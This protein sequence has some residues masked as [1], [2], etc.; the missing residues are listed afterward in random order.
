MLICWL[1]RTAWLLL[2]WLVAT[3]SATDQQ[4]GLSRL[5]P[6][7]R[8]TNA[9]STQVTLSNIS[10]IVNYPYHHQ[11]N[12]DP[13]TALIDYCSSYY[14]ISDQFCSGHGQCQPYVGC[15][16]EPNWT[17]QGDFMDLTGR[18]CQN[19]EPAILGLHIGWLIASAISLGIASYK[20]YQCSWGTYIFIIRQA[21]ELQNRKAPK[22]S[23]WQRL[24]TAAR[25][26]EE[27]LSQE[28][29]QKGVQRQVSLQPQAISRQQS[30]LA[31]E[32]ELL[33]SLRQDESYTQQSVTIDRSETRP[34][35]DRRLTYGGFGASGG[36][37]SVLQRVLKHARETSGTASEAPSEAVTRQNTAHSGVFKLITEQI[38]ATQQALDATPSAPL[39]PTARMQPAV[40]PSY[41]QVDPSQLISPTHRQT[42]SNEQSHI[43]VGIS[44]VHTPSR[45]SRTSFDQQNSPTNTA[46]TSAVSSPLSA[47]TVAA[48]TTSYES[49]AARRASQRGTVKRQTLNIGFKGMLLAA[50]AKEREKDQQQT[51][52]RVELPTIP[53]SPQLNARPAQA[54][55]SIVTAADPTVS[56]AFAKK[57]S[58]IESTNR[59]TNHGSMT[60][61][62][63]SQRKQ[64]HLALNPT[65]SMSKSLLE[66][67]QQS[68]PSSPST[69]PAPRLAIIIDTDS[70]RQ[71][72]W[73]DALPET[74][75]PADVPAAP[76]PDNTEA[77]AEA[78]T[79]QCLFAGMSAVDIP[80]PAITVTTEVGLSAT[81][82]SA[83]SADF[84]AA[85]KP[86]TTQS[87]DAA[88]LQPV[89]RRGTLHRREKSAENFLGLHSI[90]NGKRGTMTS[91]RRSGRNQLPG[92]IAEDSESG[93]VASLRR[94]RRASGRTATWAP[95]SPQGTLQLT[96]M[97]SAL[98]ITR[99]TLGPA[100]TS[101]DSS[102]DAA[103]PAAGTASRR[104]TRR[105]TSSRDMT[106]SPS[107]VSSDGAQAHHSPSSGLRS[108]LVLSNRR[109]AAV[110][111]ESSEATR[112][113]DATAVASVKAP[114]TAAAII[115]LM[116]RNA[117]NSRRSTMQ[118]ADTSGLASV[119]PPMH[120]RAMSLN[121]LGSVAAALMSVKSIKNRTDSSAVAD[122]RLSRAPSMSQKGFGS[123][124]EPLVGSSAAEAE[125]PMTGSQ[126]KAARKY[127]KDAKKQASKLR[128]QH[129]WI[130]FKVLL[131]L[132]NF[133]YSAG[134]TVFSLSSMVAAVLRIASDRRFGSSLVMN[135]L[136]VNCL[137]S[138]FIVTHTF[139]FNLLKLA[140]KLSHL[141]GEQAAQS[142]R[143]LKLCKTML[144]VSSALASLD[145]PI[146]MCIYAWPALQDEFSTLR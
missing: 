45:L 38:N 31:N 62:H 87:A 56:R 42:N 133:Q 98:A 2:T 47:A 124:K 67:I 77:K 25:R 40:R 51:A 32:N 125:T 144:A 7:Q 96:E 114:N 103:S 100:T 60:D 106:L 99:V 66:P 13:S 35:H 107:P 73:E 123:L 136:L 132:I 27:E 83:L 76:Q 97:Q 41:T 72:T 88:L 120:T 37:A 55:I 19:Y 131:S 61:S 36:L 63:S 21:E 69:T 57:L 52:L 110:T 68:T 43:S 5:R 128:R 26:K 84:I 9:D 111:Q 112:A 75:T 49:P 142:A 139:A 33:D 145:A 46:Y 64:H 121:K 3:A 71:P 23:A 119:K 109:A 44:G 115:S 54:R 101:N 138:F 91:R 1:L 94:S 118:A 53:A 8:L 79:P 129:R 116:Q 39:S 90:T 18:D 34:G 92:V 12:A 15:T 28:A 11:L 137:W 108:G 22:V 95:N 141:S 127:E 74:P 89:D 48:R 4:H 146:V 104:R 134:A 24:K 81:A 102:A 59:S 113:A 122:K 80:A 50:A 82:P 70:V 14:P 78:S 86:A 117:G 30:Q 85:S 130:T 140:F 93:N 65:A 29:K 20:L 16:C 143:F 58:V 6:V 10:T 17:G 135:F 105:A 126:Q